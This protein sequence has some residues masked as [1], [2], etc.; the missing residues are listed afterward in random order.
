M[1]QI[2]F[3]RQNQQLDYTIYSFKRLSELGE[4]ASEVC[5]AGDRLFVLLTTLEEN[6]YGQSS[7][8]SG[9]E[10]VYEN[11]CPSAG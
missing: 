10:H 7:A 6:D 4:D 11:D 8:V 1:P 9:S 3:T 5:V 2:G